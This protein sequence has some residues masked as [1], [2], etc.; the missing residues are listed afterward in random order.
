MTV[1]APTPLPRVSPQGVPLTPLIASNPA[2]GSR[3]LPGATWRTY[4]PGQAPRARTLTPGEAGSLA[5]RG[6]LG[7]KLYL[8]GRFVV[9]AAGENRAVL[10]PQAGGDDPGTP[11][12]AATRIIVEYPGGSVPPNEGT[13]FARDDARPLEIRDVRRGADGQ[14]NIY[15]REITQ[16]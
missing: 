4:A 8:R 16:P 11:L 7:E 2:P 5:D 12:P 10:R 13:T 15:T 9:T 14:I 1:P 3:T 6:D